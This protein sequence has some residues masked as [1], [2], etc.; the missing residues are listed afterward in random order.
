MTGS[1]RP[2]IILLAHRTIEPAR[3]RELLLGIE[4][5]GVPVRLATSDNLN[6]LEL[7]ASAGMTSRV[8]VGVGVSLDYVVITTDKLPESRPYIVGL[9]NESAERDRILGANAARLVKRIPLVPI[10]RTS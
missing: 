9:L 4:E 5:Q 10:R 8:G 3:L 7:A 1:E 6:P 2:A